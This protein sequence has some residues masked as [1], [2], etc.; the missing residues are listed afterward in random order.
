[1]SRVTGQGVVLAVALHGEKDRL[2]TLL[3][4]EKGRIRGL[5]KGR[6]RGVFQP[7]DGV[8]YAQFKRL[9]QQLGLLELDV[10]RSRAGLWLRGGTGLLLVNW[11]AE[12]LMAV[13]PEELPYAGLVEDVER[14]L[15]A[16]VDEGLWRRVAR[17]ELELLRMLGY[18]V[19]LADEAVPC[20]SG[21]PLTYVSPRSGRAVSVAMG[22]P[23]ADRLL[24]LPGLFGGP[25]QEVW[26]DCRDS[27]RLTGYFIHAGWPQVRLGAR[28]RL[29]EALEQNLKQRKEEGAGHGECAETLARDAA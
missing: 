13:L 8:Q 20:E 23:F 4:R 14:L 3:C 27:L 17:F 1:M 16:G 26:Q 9:P 6:A 29:V 12:L 25:R 10:V 15:G 18:G 5:V 7:L 28:A 2:V 24:T 21:T 19:Q 11:L 22:A